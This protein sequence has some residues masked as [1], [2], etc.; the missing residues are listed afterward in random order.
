MTKEELYKRALEATELSYAPYSNFHVG[1]AVLTKNGKVFTGCNVENASYSVS[2][3][4]ERVAL[5]K[6]ISEGFREIEAIAIAARSED[7]VKSAPPCG[8]C[9]QFISEFG[10]DIEVIFLSSEGSLVSEKIASLLP[11]GFEL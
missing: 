2:I 10:K 6:A 1:A 9:R 8:T 4:A 3:C 5:T 7:E 11:R